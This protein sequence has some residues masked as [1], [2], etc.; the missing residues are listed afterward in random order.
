[1]TMMRSLFSILILISNLSVS[2][3]K[4]CDL[5]CQNDGVCKFGNANFTLMLPVGGGGGSSGGGTSSSTH[6][7]VTID[8]L[9]MTN[10][11]G[12]FCNCN[13]TSNTTNYT[14]VTCN[15]QYE[16]C[17]DQKNICYHGGKCHEVLLTNKATNVTTSKMM[18]DCT[19][20]KNE[21]SGV[22]AV[23]EHCE[24]TNT[25]TNTSTGQQ[26]EVRTVCATND[27]LRF[28][29]NRGVCTTEEEFEKYVYH[30]LLLLYSFNLKKKNNW[31]ETTI[32][33]NL[34]Y[35]IFFLI[36]LHS[37]QGWQ[38][39]SLQIWHNGEA[40]RI[41]WNGECKLHCQLQKWGQVSHWTPECH[42]RRN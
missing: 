27:P 39:L 3:A 32:T 40:L 30:V 22:S 11:D 10:V 24:N 14:G 25:I 13:G 36:G 31:H 28:C 18:C 12:M 38:Y 42:H 16:S 19:N 8:F 21:I 35:Y 1:M 7:N 34:T 2:T 41:L 37:T 20:A 9:R 15:S 6:S 33:L 17:I 23:G 5:I 4:D 26:Q 29:V